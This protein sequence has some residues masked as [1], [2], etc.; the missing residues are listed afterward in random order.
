MKPTE[1]A[2]LIRGTIIYE[3]ENRECVTSY[4]DPIV[5]FVAASDPGFSNLS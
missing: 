4:R 3:V 5:G 1:L 2:D